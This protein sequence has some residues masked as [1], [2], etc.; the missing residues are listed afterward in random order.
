MKISLNLSMGLAFLIGVIFY[1][2]LVKRDNMNDKK[3]EEY[4]KQEEEDYF[5]VRYSK[6]LYLFYIALAIP[7]SFVVCA[8]HFKSYILLFSE[9]GVVVLFTVI[10]FI[11]KSCILIVY[12][13]GQITRYFAGRERLTGNV[14]D[15]DAKNTF[16]VFVSKISPDVS[17]NSC[18]TFNDGSHMFFRS[19]DMDNGYKLA[20]VLKRRNLFNP[21]WGKGWGEK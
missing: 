12:D 18:I 19:E 9:M 7:F 5:E 4:M 3:I 14:N 21:K 20:C 10:L 1:I 16:S 8:P 6:K 17:H 13:H 11:Y 15:I 2:V